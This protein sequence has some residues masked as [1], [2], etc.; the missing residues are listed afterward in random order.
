[1]SNVVSWRVMDVDVDSGKITVMY[2]DSFRN[3]PIIFNWNADMG[4]LINQIY[5]CA[6]NFEDQWN[7]PK[8]TEQEKQQ[9]LQLS[10]D[11][12]SV[13][14]NPTFSSMTEVSV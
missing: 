8:M 10:G 3:A 5:A 2:E 9:I 1:M 6:K 13:P 14:S 7:A 12:S 4:I 11:S